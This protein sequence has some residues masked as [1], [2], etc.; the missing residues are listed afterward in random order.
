MAKS[1][2]ALA[3]RLND[4]PTG[5]SPGSRLICL[6]RP[7]LQPL[8]LPAE[9]PPP[10]SCFSHCEA[11]KWRDLRLLIH[12]GPWV[13]TFSLPGWKVNN[14]LIT[15]LRVQYGAECLQIFI[16]VCEPSQ[17][18]PFTLLIHLSLYNSACSWGVAA[19]WLLGLG[20]SLT[21]PSQPSSPLR[22][23][24][25][26]SWGLREAKPLPERLLSGMSHVPNGAV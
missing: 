11:C 1:L 15:L 2:A 5:A 3:G 24:A 13:Y 18:A 22:V 4:W 23:D 7:V 25:E 19:S 14:E 16:V 8:S 9:H 17:T 6:D 20:E 10:T 21:C 12:A 26:D